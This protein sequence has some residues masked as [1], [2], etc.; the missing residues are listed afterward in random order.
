MIK[1]KLRFNPFT[2]YYEVTSILP[3]GLIIVLSEFK[4]EYEG[5]RAINMC[6][7]VRDRDERDRLKL[8]A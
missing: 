8:A 5:I 2:R 7:V 4:D 1:L 3:N 6:N